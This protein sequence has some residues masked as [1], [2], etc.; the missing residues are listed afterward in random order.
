MVSPERWR[1]IQQA[2]FAIARYQCEICGWR[3]GHLHCHEV[4][5]YNDRT[6][7]QRLAGFLALCRFCHEVKH[8]GLAKVDGRYAPALAHLAR[9]NR[10][11]RAVAVEYVDACFEQFERRSEKEWRLDVTQ[12][13]KMM[14][15]G[16]D[17]LK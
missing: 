2:V 17:L 10:W 8:I 7:V 16:L 15:P 3:G 14:P 9:V 1:D 12:A 5:S 4:W 13:L 6:G 11:S